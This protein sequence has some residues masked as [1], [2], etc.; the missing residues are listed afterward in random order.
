MLKFVKYFV[1]SMCGVVCMILGSVNKVWVV[2]FW[3]V[4][5]LVGVV[6]VRGFKISLE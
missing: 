2:W 6:V 3:V 4:L 5:R 1:V